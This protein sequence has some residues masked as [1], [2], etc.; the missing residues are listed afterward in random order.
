MMGTQIKE[1]VMNLLL[2]RRTPPLFDTF[3]S[4][5][6]EVLQ[7]FFRNGGEPIESMTTWAPQVDVEETDKAMVVKAD[8]PGVEMKDV[9]VSIQDRTLTL[10]GE[11]REERQE[12]LKQFHRIERFA[13]SFFRSVLLPADAD[14]EKVSA[15]ANKGVITITIPKAAGS[16]PRKVAVKEN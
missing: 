4:E 7:R 5:M 13:G 8:L 16:Q 12:N 6:D 9:D 3:R 15:V 2:R 14:L 11:K 10:R 1:T